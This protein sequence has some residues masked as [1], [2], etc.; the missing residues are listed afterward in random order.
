MPRGNL[1]ALATTLESVGRGG[2]TTLEP[3]GRGGA[4]TLKPLGRGGEARGMQHEA[5][6]IFARL[7]SPGNDPAAPVAGTRR[8][9]D[10]AETADRR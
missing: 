10:G 4:T 6:E 9:P 8:I 1:R 5:A 3:L 2:A 7:G